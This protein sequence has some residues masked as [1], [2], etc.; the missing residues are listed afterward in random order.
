MSIDQELWMKN[1]VRRKVFVSDIVIRKS[2]TPDP[3]T[4]GQDYKYEI[5]I[6]INSGGK[7][8]TFQHSIHGGKNDEYATKYLAL[9][10]NF[11][12]LWFSPDIPN[13][14]ALERL[15]SWDSLLGILLIFLTCMLAP[16]I[17]FVKCLKH[18]ISLSSGQ[19]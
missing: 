5:S 4:N 19:T 6:F 7:V 16:L 13:W 14:A 11:A 3:I 9:K 17:H 2:V 8:Q 18:W 1:A 10:N 15:S 12:E